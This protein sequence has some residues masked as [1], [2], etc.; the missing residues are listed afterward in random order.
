MSNIKI[1]KPRM[2]WLF[3]GIGFHNSEASMTALMSE[4]F[5]NERA[6][7][8]FG[9]I[10]PT[11]SRVYAG[12][13][14]WTK[15]AMD[16]F[17][18]Y[19]DK[20]FKK[21]GT[22]LY[23][24]PGRMPMMMDDFDIEDYC[25]RVASKLDY[26]INVRGCVKARYYCVTNELSCGNT[27]AYLAKDLDLFAKLHKELY[28]AFDRHGLDIGLLA[29]DCSGVK[30]F[31]QIKWA[32]ENMD[33][34][35]EAYCAHLY[36]YDYEPGNMG[37]YDY[38][39]QSFSMPV[40]EARRKEKRFILGEYGIT[41][42]EK[43]AN[44]LPMGNDSAYAV[45]FPEREG[46]YAIALAEM[47]IAAMNSGC[48]SGVYWTMFDYPDPFIRENGDSDRE[49]AIYDAARFSGHGLAFRYNKNGLIKW[50][51]D[52][53]D[54]SSRASLYTMGYMA[55]LFKKGSRVL[56]SRW[57]DSSIRCGAVT[58]ADGSV[59]IA[60]VNWKNEADNV[61]IELEHMCDKPLRKY[62]FEASNIPYNDFCDLQGHSSLVELSEGCIKTILPPKSV[63]FL[64]T[65]YCD[66]IPG[67]I[68]NIRFSGSRLVWDKCKEEEHCYYRVYASLDRDFVP[69]ADN[70]IA[71]S[72]AESIRIRDKTLFYKVLS[73]DK[74]GNTRK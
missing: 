25:E 4:E 29:T 34:V 32:T 37:A 66:R 62:I 30:N 47:S 27:Y 57:E 24:V 72:V 17:A 65:D 36:N 7:K 51:D 23:L 26:L 1:S 58:N 41:Y 69:G 12:Y 61:T 44:G 39:C 18:D 46:E 48:F 38:F 74:W 2:R 54:Y 70:Q 10:S 6:L 68:K 21:A 60:V 28:K 31:D 11:F 19:Y 53:K 42:K 49:K 43:W 13:A 63:V 16:A 20:T 33:E 14:D 15:E 52:E 3:G 64:T 5:L 71:S 45:D 40:N 35:T 55:K 56:E 22:L 50:C 67:E 8:V 73:V 9:E 59:S